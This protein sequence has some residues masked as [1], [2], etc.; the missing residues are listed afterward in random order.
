MSLLDF[1][2]RAL[3][4]HM[5]SQGKIA[6]K[7]KVSVNNS[8]DMT[9]AYTPGVAEPCLKIKNDYDRIYDY[10][11]K[12][13]WVAV[14]TNGT[15]V[16]GL[17]DIGAGAGLP[18]MEGKALL[19]KSFAGVD[20][21]PICLDT[22]DPDR[23]VEAVRLLEPG[24]GGINLEDIKAPECFEIEE[25]LKSVSDIPV[26]HDDQ[27]GTAVVVGAAL[28]NAMKLTHRKADD[29]K[30]VVNGAGAA[31]TA[32][33]KLILSMGA[34]DI[35]VCDRCGALSTDDDSLNA[36]MKKLAKLTNPD[37]LAGPLSEIVKG[38]DVFIGVSAPGVLTADMVR[39]MA[40][41]PIVFAM[42]NPTPEIMP[43]D[44]KRGG[45]RIFGTGRSDYPNQINNVLAFPGI[46]RG[47]LDVRASEINERMTLAAARAIAG[48]IPDAE[49]SEE[50]IIPSPFDR[51]VAPAVAA[52][53]AEAAIAG[54]TARREGVTPA[55]VADHTRKL[56]QIA[57]DD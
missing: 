26:F 35:V 52:A 32:V 6:L 11:S 1:K 28:I 20:A 29:L 38:R 34:K 4:L 19:F 47:A 49:L 53:V 48:V 30:V 23:I 31:G 3:K 13:N 27:H 36:A 14:V 5:D 51:R 41:D 21:F 55:W 25:R 56:V 39:S 15:A 46:F 42:A 18:V 12:G 43:A 2:E 54:G 57:H 9:L 33:A 37:D 24:F 10:T 22:H 8:E 17:G 16:L 40:D 50:Y 7:C 44:A 45:V